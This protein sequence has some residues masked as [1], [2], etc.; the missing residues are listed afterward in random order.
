MPNRSDFNKSSPAKIM[1]IKGVI[2]NI[3]IM[4]AISEKGIEMSA[5]KKPASIK[6]CIMHEAVNKESREYKKILQPNRSKKLNFLIFCLYI[7]SKFNTKG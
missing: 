7:F 2:K 4:P 1:K 6:T 5:F 3:Q